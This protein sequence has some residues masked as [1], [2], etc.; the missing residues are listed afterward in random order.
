M[1]DT[2]PMVLHPDAKGR[3]T[4]GKLANGVS[5]FHA[6]VEQDGSVRLVPH[7]E[8]PAREKWVWEHKAALASVRR[9]LD[10]SAAGRTQS[11]GDFSRYADDD[12]GE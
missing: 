8:I 9:G 5:S 2:K 10:D 7:V 6:I 4:L 3:I 1:R 11:L 12:S